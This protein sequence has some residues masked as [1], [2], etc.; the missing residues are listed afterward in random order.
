MM[1]MLMRT[2]TYCWISKTESGKGFTEAE[3][4][5]QRASQ[6]VDIATCRSRP[7]ASAKLSASIELMKLK[8]SHCSIASRYTYLKIDGFVYDHFMPLYSR[9]S[10]K[11]DQ[12]FNLMFNRDSSSTVNKLISFCCEATSGTFQI[13]VIIF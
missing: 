10:Y 4:E 2:Y 3:N 8:H 5:Q 1:L 12:S 11:M 13:A 6:A 9:T 7:S